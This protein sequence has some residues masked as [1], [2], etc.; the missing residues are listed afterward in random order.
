[1][2]LTTPVPFVS[3]PRILPFSKK[4]IFMDAMPARLSPLAIISTL[5]I[6]DRTLLNS[7]VSLLARPERVKDLI[8]V[9]SLSPIPRSSGRIKFPCAIRL[10][11]PIGRAKCFD[12]WIADICKEF[13]LLTASSNGITLPSKCQNL[14][15]QLLA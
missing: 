14:I 4:C 10:P 13:R 15:C 8:V 1:M 9:V 6:S 3:Y 11:L 12:C 2:E 5:T 7:A